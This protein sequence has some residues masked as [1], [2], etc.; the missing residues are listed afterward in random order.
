MSGT[1]VSFRSRNFQLSQCWEYLNKELKTLIL[2]VIFKSWPNGLAS[3]RKFLTFVSF[4]HPLAWTYDDFGRA[5]TRMQLHARFKRKS[6]QVERKSAVY[7]WN[8]P[9]FVICVNLLACEN[10]RIFNQLP[11]GAKQQAENPSVF[12]G[13]DWTCESTCESVWSPIASLYVSCGSANLH[14]LASACESVCQGFRS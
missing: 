4:G 14:R 2:R 7:V 10:R 12:A 5:Q 1:F 9:L 6:T 3:R 11:G 13:H 8:L